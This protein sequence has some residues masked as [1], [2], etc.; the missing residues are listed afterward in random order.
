MENPKPKVRHCMSCQNN[1][2]HDKHFVAITGD[3]I[4]CED[5]ISECNSLISRGKRTKPKLVTN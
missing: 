5:C 4:L 2:T 3:L 1:T